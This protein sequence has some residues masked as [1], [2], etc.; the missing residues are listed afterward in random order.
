MSKTKIPVNFNNLSV[1]VKII[2]FAKVFFSGIYFAVKLTLISKYFS[3]LS[4]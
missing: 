3:I 2:P 1:S 4:F